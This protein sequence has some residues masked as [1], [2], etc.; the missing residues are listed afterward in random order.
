[1]TSTTPSIGTKGVM[2]TCNLSC[3]TDLS[4]KSGNENAT[5]N[6]INLTLKVQVLRI[7]KLLEHKAL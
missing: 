5:W 3:H 4:L 2:A 7:L 1:M 6:L